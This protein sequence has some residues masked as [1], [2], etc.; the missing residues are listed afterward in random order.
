MDV[1]KKLFS[2]VIDQ[3]DIKIEERSFEPRNGMDVHEH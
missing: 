2:S 1:F 3:I